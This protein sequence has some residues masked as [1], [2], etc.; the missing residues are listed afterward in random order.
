MENLIKE[1]QAGRLAFEP[2]LVICD[3]PGAKALERAEALGVEAV[4]VDRKQYDSKDA[5]EKE[6]DRQL[7]CREVDYIILAGF[8]RILSEDFVNRHLGTMIN[9]HPSYLPAFP[10]AHGIR[11]AFEARV[12]ET[13]VTVHFVI[14][15]VD[16]GPVILQRKIPI[17]SDDTLESLE[18]RIHAEEYK[19]YPEALK[20]VAEGKSSFKKPT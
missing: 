14:P 4:L 10:G 12:S 20:L 2:A 1:I 9:I 5:F 7:A 11:D 8:M 19:I 17:H 16:A 6:I 15:E 18:T 3:K 13:G